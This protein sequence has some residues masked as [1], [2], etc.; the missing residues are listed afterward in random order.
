VDLA[1]D[2]FGNR[3]VEAL[4]NEVSTLWKRTGEAL[5]E[6]VS[7]ATWR[8]WLAG[9]GPLSFDGDLLVMAAPSTLVRDRVET[10]F[11]SL[12]MAAASD[13][14]GHEVK[15]RL[16]VAPPASAAPYSEGYEDEPPASLAPVVP[17]SRPPTPPPPGVGETNREVRKP[18]P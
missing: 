11:L 6:Q 5:R 3:R 4:V 12:L 10:R 2:R 18:P 9:L 13:A 17:A 16:E 14:A 1:V 8:T 15:V 7:D